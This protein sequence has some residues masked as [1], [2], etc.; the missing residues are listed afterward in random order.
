MSLLDLLR[1]AIPRKRGRRKEAQS[2]VGMCGSRFI[3]I[4]PVAGSFLKRSLTSS[5]PARSNSNSPR[6]HSRSRG[7][8]RLMKRSSATAT[9]GTSIRGTVAI[10]P[11][12]R[13]DR[14]EVVHDRSRPSLSL[15]RC[16][17]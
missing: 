15:A 10:D 16:L 3:V 2:Y 13:V 6:S 4:S 8:R 7:L 17:V 12:R 1:P 11:K 14:D 5:S 9:A